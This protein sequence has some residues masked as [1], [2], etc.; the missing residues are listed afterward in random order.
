M[1]QH[2]SVSRPK[3]VLLTWK[4]HRLGRSAYTVDLRREGADMQGLFRSPVTSP[5]QKSRVRRKFPSLKPHHP[6]YPLPISCPMG[7]WVRFPILHS[8]FPEIAGPPRFTD[9]QTL[10]GSCSAGMRV[11]AVSPLPTVTLPSS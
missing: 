10:A 4:Y 6:A 1:I 2:D 8:Q 3:L 5:L 7:P 11:Y 9:P